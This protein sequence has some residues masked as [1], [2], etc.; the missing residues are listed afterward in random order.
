MFGMTALPLRASAPPSTNCGS[1]TGRRITDR[2]T[3]HQ[4]SLRE[5]PGGSADRVRL[6]GYTQQR[7]AVIDL[8]LGIVDSKQG[9]G[10][11]KPG[12]IDF[13]I[14]IVNSNARIVNSKL[15]V[16]D[17][18]LVIV[19]SKLRITETKL[20]IAGL[21]LRMR[22]SKPRIA[23]LAL[24]FPL[25]LPSRLEKHGRNMLLHKYL[26]QSVCAFS[27]CQRTSEPTPRRRNECQDFQA[28][29][30]MSLH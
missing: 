17:S 3:A 23:Y 28:E 22:D 26:Q 8:K 19:S 29:N 1:R 12:I 14:G 11:L 21:K 27:C 25:P 9:I 13:N 30:P 6:E 18:K 5:A 15:R 24:R 4:G 10:Y 2:V 20:G 16:I 7:P